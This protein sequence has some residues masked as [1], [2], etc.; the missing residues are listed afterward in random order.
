LQCHQCGFNLKLPSHCPECKG[1]DS[2]IACGPGVERIHEQILQL[3]P[4]ARC[5]MLTS[6]TLST[7]KQIYDLIRR[8]AE[9]EIDVVIGTQIL[10]KGHHFP[11]MT[12]V[13]VIDADLGLSGGDL[14]ACERT[15]QL[16]HQVSGRAGREMLPGQVL[17]QTFNPEHPVITALV[18]QDRDS[19]ITAE[20]IEREAR[21][22]PPFGRLGAIIISGTNPHQVEQMAKNM[23]RHAPTH[24]DMTVLGPVPAP[25][26]QL[27]GRHR[28]RLLVK[29]SKNV[30]L[31]N[32][33]SHWIGCLKIPGDIRI[34]IDI[35]PYN[36]L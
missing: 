8:I 34:A 18:S 6:D 1:E 25:L 33:L 27:R 15:Y 31:Q 28:W 24:P 10:A 12:L 14:R 35:D 11:M 3:F 5:E 20:K 36:F 30:P 21:M 2:L 17:L 22:M 29:A 13:G 26:A 4:K 23:I 9:H 19:F 16:L 32:M 7:P